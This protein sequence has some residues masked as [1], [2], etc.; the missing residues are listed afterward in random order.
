MSHL[1][2]LTAGAA[3]PAKNDSAADRTVAQG[4][5]TRWAGGSDAC[6]AAP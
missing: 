6:N 5:M 4:P 3:C 2:L 1:S